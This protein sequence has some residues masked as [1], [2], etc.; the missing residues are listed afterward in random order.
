ML[1]MCLSGELVES[2][3]AITSYSGFQ[4]HLPV[5]PELLPLRVPLAVV[6][7]VPSATGPRSPSMQS[8][9]RAQHL[10]FWVNW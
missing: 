10:A 7:T 3:V 2:P 5:Y 9:A 6:N 4:S 1:R 8:P